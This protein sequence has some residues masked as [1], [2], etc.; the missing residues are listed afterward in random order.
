MPR[1]IHLLLL[2]LLFV[3]VVVTVYL[4]SVDCYLPDCCC[5]IVIRDV[6]VLIVV[7]GDGIQYCSLLLLLFICCCCVTFAVVCWAFDALLHF[8]IH[9]LLLLYIAIRCSVYLWFVVCTVNDIC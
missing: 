2:Q 4:R 5:R 3:V 7:V 1:G 9:L 6:V 8:I